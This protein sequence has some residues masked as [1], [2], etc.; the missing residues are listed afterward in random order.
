M[1][2]E[3][4]APNALCDTFEMLVDRLTEVEQTTRAIFDVLRFNAES[5]PAGQIIPPSLLG[6]NDGIRVM[7]HYDGTLNRVGYVS[8][9]T[10]IFA[11]MTPVVESLEW[12]SGKYRMDMDSAVEAAIGKVKADEIRHRVHAYL[13]AHPT[14]DDGEMVDG[15]LKAADV[16]LDRAC[17]CAYDDF[18]TTWCCIGIKQLVPE[19]VAIGSGDLIIKL[20]P[21][22]N[23]CGRVMDVVARAH[24]VI[25]NKLSNSWPYGIYWI[26]PCFIPLVEAV[27]TLETRWK[28]LKAWQ[29]K[30]ISARDKPWEDKWFTSTFCGQEDVLRSL[31]YRELL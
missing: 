16:G 15:W 23:D 12:A 5:A 31:I 22:C 26:R 10:D 1:G 6:R 21:D 8:V 17:A 25:G 20:G 2:G 4:V 13:M 29:K 24:G 3:D 7:K 14:Y 19:V 11:D 18:S 28:S 27:G 9:S 30:A